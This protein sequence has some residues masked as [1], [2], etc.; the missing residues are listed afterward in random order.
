MFELTPAG[1]GGWTERVLH[2]FGGSGRDF[3]YGGLIFDGAGNL[4]GTTSMGGTYSGGR[5]SS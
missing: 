2:T 4:Y 1:G 5:C 3:P